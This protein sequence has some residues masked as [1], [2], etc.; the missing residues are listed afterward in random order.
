MSV[1]GVFSMKTIEDL[2]SEITQFEYIREAEI[3]EVY[4]VPCVVGRLGNLPIIPLVH[5]DKE[6]GFPYLHIHYDFRFFYDLELR[7]FY[8]STLIGKS[9][10]AKFSAVQVLNY[11]KNDD[12]SNSR[13][14]GED[15][16]TK[17]IIE[18]RRCFRKPGIPDDSLCKFS[19]KSHS[20]ALLN[21]ESNKKLLDAGICPH[22]FHKFS[23]SSVTGKGKSGQTFHCPLHGLKFQMTTGKMLRC[24]AK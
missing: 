23:K 17:F 13:T 2:L 24:G 15:K 8:E 5:E 21:N 19:F 12:F 9:K 1:F 18:K 14:P 7:E 4:G 16:T 3:G 6:I 20:K 10:G 11:K 22:K